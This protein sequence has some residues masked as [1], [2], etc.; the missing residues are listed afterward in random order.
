MS[1]HSKSKLQTIG[2]VIL[3]LNLSGCAWLPWWKSEDPI[4][5]NKKAV[6]RTPLALPDPSPVRPTAVEWLVVT[7]ENVDKV[8]ELLKKKNADLVLFAVT[9]DGYETL[10]TDMAQIRNYMAQQREIIIRY[11][12]Y[13]EPKK[14]ETK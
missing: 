1:S 2:A 12:E 9:D 11:R 5:I 3:C 8:W 13:Y 6:E 7:P 14:P 4:V 10:A